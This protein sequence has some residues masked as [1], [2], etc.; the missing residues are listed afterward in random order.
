MAREGGLTW[1]RGKGRETAFLGKGS[2]FGM[3]DISRTRYVVDHI[4]NE[5]NVPESCISRDFILWHVNFTSIN[6]LTIIFLVVLLKFLK[7]NPSFAGGKRQQHDAGRN[8][9]L[10]VRSLDLLSLLI[11]GLKAITLCALSLSVPLYRTGPRQAA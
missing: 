10:Q 4:G 8:T 1:G 5:R 2:D 7:E 9:S 11:L 6:Y 3:T